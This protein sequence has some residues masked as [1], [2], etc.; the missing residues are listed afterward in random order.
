MANNH[1][2]IIIGENAAPVEVKIK[3][4]ARQVGYFRS[5]P[6][7]YS[8]EEIEIRSRKERIQK[9]VAAKRQSCGVDR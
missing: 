9:P 5:F 8:Q 2:D 3:V 6:L 4:E 7:H 1:L